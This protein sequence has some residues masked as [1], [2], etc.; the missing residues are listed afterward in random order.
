VP[1]ATQSVPEAPVS[2]HWVTVSFARRMQVPLLVQQ[3]AQLD[4]LHPVVVPLHWPSWQ[5]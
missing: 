3:P 1:Q 4:A 2:P 5:T